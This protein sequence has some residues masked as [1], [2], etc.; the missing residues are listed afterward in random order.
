MT[1]PG[2]GKFSSRPQAALAQSAQ[3]SAVIALP[4]RGQLPPPDAQVVPQLEQVQTLHLRSLRFAAG[5]LTL[6]PVDAAAE[7]AAAVSPEHTSSNA[8]EDWGNSGREKNSSQTDSAN[9]SQG[10]IS[11]KP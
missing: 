10:G 2:S 1:A 3:L 4:Q 11:Q 6:L 7:T 9:S 5:Q 8:Q